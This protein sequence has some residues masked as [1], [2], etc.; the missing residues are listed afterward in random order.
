MA[1][2]SVWAPY[3]V[4]A[5][6]CGCRTCGLIRCMSTC[7]VHLSESCVIDLIIVQQL[8]YPLPLRLRAVCSL[9]GLATGW[10]WL[11]ESE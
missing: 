1:H 10:L 2:S 11:K 7:T 8:L 3:G 4:Y 9:M 5:C 6:V